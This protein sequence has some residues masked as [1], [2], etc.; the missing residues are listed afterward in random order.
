MPVEMS[1]ARRPFIATDMAFVATVPA[2]VAAVCAVVDAV[3]ATCAAVPPA[4]AVL[5]AVCAAVSAAV[6]VA[7]AT[8]AAVLIS[9]AA[10]SAACS[11][12]LCPVS[13]FHHS[14]RPFKVTRVNAESLLRVCCICC[15]PMVIA[16]RDC[17]LTMI[18]C[19][20][21][22]S[23]AKSDIVP[24]ATEKAPATPESPEIR[25][26]IP[27]WS[28]ARIV[29]CAVASAHAS[30]SFPA[31]SCKARYCAVPRCPDASIITSSSRNCLNRVR[32]D[33]WLLALFSAAAASFFNRCSV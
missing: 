10:V 11:T 27:R 28:W 2:V 4:V 16:M 31:S 21:S 19:K 3:F 30:V 15:N 26:C 12:A 7:L 9:V 33:T 18:F 5:L 8:C 32:S 23:P 22:F 1:A 24:C 14:L 25:P 13:L 17:T 20:S 29:A 6:A